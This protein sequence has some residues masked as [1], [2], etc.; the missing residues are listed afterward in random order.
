MIYVNQKQAKQLVMLITKSIDVREMAYIGKRYISAAL[1]VNGCGPTNIHLLI[2]DFNLTHDCNWHDF[3][4]NTK[5]YGLANFALQR[6]R[7]ARFYS[8]FTNLF[9]K[10]SKKL[11]PMDVN[12]LNDMLRLVFLK[13]YHTDSSFD[14][15]ASIRKI[16]GM[17]LTDFKDAIKP[18]PTDFYINNN[19]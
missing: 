1:N 16:L 13:T 18:I 9:G 4:Y 10:D 17:T 19:K 12:V 7:L 15:V 6:T 14:L 11:N 2:P 8:F 5:S 3:F